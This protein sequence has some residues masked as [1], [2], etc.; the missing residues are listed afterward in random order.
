MVGALGS[1][2]PT[3]LRGPAVDV[4]NDNGGAPSMFLCVDGGR[5]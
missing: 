1:L 4:F 5:S 3:P 2:A